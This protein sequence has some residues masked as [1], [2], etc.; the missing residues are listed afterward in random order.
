MDEEIAEDFLNTDIDVFIGG[1][2]TFFENR[3]DG[4]NLLDDLKKNGYA[5][6]TG[7]RSIAKTK[8][9]KL[10]GFLDD[11]HPPKMS[12]GRG[13]MLTLASI[14][15]IGLLSQNKNGFFLMVEGSQIDWAGHANDS[16]YL[17]Q[18][19]IDFDNAIGKVLDFAD[20]DKNTLVIVTSDHE[21]GGYSVLGGSLDSGKVEGSFSTGY[22]TPVMVPVFAFGPGAEKFT[23]IYHNN[24][25]FNK[26]KEVMKLDQETLQAL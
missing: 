7:I 5:I 8:S 21:T 17:V 3:T 26:M 1:G 11:L 10:A 9:G 14:T 2:K 13:Q 16:E 19:M 18:E 22:H 6:K 15:A 25:L 24:A 12:E 20:K 4:R 23:G